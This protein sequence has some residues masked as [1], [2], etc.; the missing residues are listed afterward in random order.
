M[1]SDTSKSRNDSSASLTY[2]I[3]LLQLHEL[4]CTHIF[5]YIVV[6]GKYALAIYS[7][8]HDISIFF[9]PAVPFHPQHTSVEHFPTAVA[10]LSIGLVRPGILMYVDASVSKQ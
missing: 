4:L 9:L 5:V 1:L 7:A 6:V 3:A 8:L 10:N 2:Q